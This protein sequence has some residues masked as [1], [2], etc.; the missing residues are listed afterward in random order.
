MRK[1]SA[2]VLLF[3]AMA[4]GAQS[5]RPSYLVPHNDAR[6]RWARAFSILQ[7]VV[8]QSH[9]GLLTNRELYHHLNRIPLRDESPLSLSLLD[10]VQI[11]EKGPWHYEEESLDFQSGVDFN[12]M[13]FMG[14]GDD[15]LREWEVGRLERDALIRFPFEISLFDTWYSKIGLGFF[16]DPFYILDTRESHTNIYTSFG[17][18][19]MHLPYEAI[20]SFSGD[21]WNVQAGRDR[22][23]WGL[24]Q[25]ANL[26]VSDAP[27]Y[28]DFFSLNTWWESFRFSFLWINTD[29]YPWMENDS[30]SEFRMR[31]AGNHRFFRPAYTQRL[32]DDYD[33]L[34]PDAPPAL[35]ALST[36]EGY[37]WF[38]AHRL[39]FRPA[40]W[41][42]II[43]TESIFFQDQAFQPRY[44]NPLYAFHNWYLDGNADINITLEVAWAVFPG[45]LF[46]SQILGDQIAIGINRTDTTSQTYPGALGYLAGWQYI[47][48]LGEGYLEWGGEGV[49]VDPYAYIDRSGI[50]HYVSQRFVSNFYRGEHI[51]LD[52]PLGFFMGPDSAMLWSGFRYEE[53]QEFS[54]ALEYQWRIKGRQH[55]HTPW[56]RE[57]GEA[58][59]T[60]PT[61][62][63]PII[64][65]IA[66][67]GG[68]K[69]LGFL[70]LPLLKSA[71]LTN[72]FIWT[73][74]KVDWGPVGSFDQVTHIETDYRFDYQL[75]FW[76]KGSY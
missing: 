14:A 63:H 36:Q 69:D 4:L 74:N 2:L 37:K 61:G 73:K 53:P 40:P 66:T 19:D 51:L 17:Q 72:H 49:M 21:H 12:L 28:H 67:F 8:P 75:S 11:G 64:N 25:K 1:I 27:F 7:G 42:E 22:F 38:L 32:P 58:L 68:E 45:L 6:L 31:Y 34:D 62:A 44:L 76:V 23:S 52:S 57:P 43:F 35:Q 55:L 71:G 41:L 9:S 30:G 54:L 33:P 3:L 60:T 18:V 16:D 48:P 15:E 65:H 46:Y 47:L 26:L 29:N 5:F 50:N 56:S 20:M 39:E 13:G 70:G 24:G 10:L 59:K